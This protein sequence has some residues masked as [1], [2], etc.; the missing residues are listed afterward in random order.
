M[1]EKMRSRSPREVARSEQMRAP[2]EVTA[3]LRL[4]QLGLLET[5]GENHV[6]DTAGKAAC[7]A[8]PR[9]RLLSSDPLFKFA[10][11]DL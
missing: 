2:D 11:V 8:S 1:A 6:G 9:Q 5:G 3:M 7:V 10:T 4:R